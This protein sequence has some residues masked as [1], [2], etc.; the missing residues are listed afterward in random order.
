MGNKV[1]FD[2]QKIMK[3]IS[4]EG[5]FNFLLKT[6]KYIR[7]NIYGIRKAF[8]FELDLEKKYPKVNTDFRLSFRLASEDD[9][10]SMD[11][12]HYD[13]N[14]KSKNYSKQRLKKGDKCILAINNDK[15]IG[16]M[17]VM[18][19]QMELAE[20]KYQSLNEDMSYTYKGFVLEQYRGNRVLS[21]MYKYLIDMLKKEGKH[22]IITAAD[23][24]NKSS[25]KALERLCFKKI[26]ILYHIK[27]FGL[28]KDFIKNNI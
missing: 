1:F 20:N 17:W 5:L 21:A 28:N 14:G 9:I 22:L 23:L 15:I 19:N 7:D 13:Y 2:S 18:N 11:E 25:I 4:E 24:D 6:K 12:K 16:Y 10:E 8:V 27:F 26:G 3:L